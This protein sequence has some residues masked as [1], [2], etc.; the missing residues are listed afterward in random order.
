MG[1]IMAK[2]WKEVFEN[3]AYKD[4]NANQR[5]KAREQYWD[6]QIKPKIP[7]IKR[8]AV[9][10][11]FYDYT[12]TLEAPSGKA[13][14]WIKEYGKSSFQPIKR[15]AGIGTGVINSPLAFIW[16]SQAA[17]LKDP[18]QY[19]ALP[20]WKKV[21]VG[22]G[23]GFESAW[24]SATRKG[25]WGTLYGE[26]FEEKTGMTI[27]ESL[28][29]NLK[30]AAPTLEFTANLVSDPLILTPAIK[31]L[32]RFKIP[33]EF[34]GKLPSSFFDEFSKMEKATKEEK[35]IL[36]AKL[37]EIIKTREDYLTFFNKKFGHINKEILPA[38]KIK[39]SLPPTPKEALLV[40]K[41]QIPVDAQVADLSK[42]VEVFKR[43]MDVFSKD[44][45]L[46]LNKMNKKLKKLHSDNIPRKIFAAFGENPDVKLT[47]LKQIGL[48]NKSEQLDG[49]AR[50]YIR[51]PKTAFEGSEQVIQKLKNSLIE[52]KPREIENRLKIIE[53][54]KTFE[55]SVET[56]K[57]RMLDNA[58]KLLTFDDKNLNKAV[59]KE[60]GPKYIPAKIN[61]LKASGGVI[62]GVDEDENGNLV[63][64]V[65]KGLLGLVTMVGGVKL[66]KKFKKNQFEK[67][68]SKY[69]AWAR[70]TGMIGKKPKEVFDFAG[71]LS[72]LNVS[73]L[74]RF[75]K[76][77]D[78]SPEAY[79]QA[80]I[81]SSY[82]DSTQLKFQK[83]VD[84]FSKVKD[85]EV[86]MTDYILAHRA[87]DRARR[88]M[89][90]PN[91]V[92]LAEAEETIKNIEDYYISIGK[93][94]SDLKSSLR[95]F[96]NWT[97]KY[98][99]EDFNK[100]GLLSDEAYLKILEDNEWYATFDVIEHMP[101]SLDKIPAL[102]TREYFNVG[103]QDVIKAAKGTE[104][105][106]DDPVEATIRKFARAQELIARNKVVNT[107]IN[108]PKSQS[109]IRPVA[110]SKKEFFQMK[111]QGMNPIMDRA[112]SGNFDVINRMNNGRV[113]RYIAPKEIVEALKQLNPVQVPKMLLSLNNIFRSAA[114]TVYLPFTISNAFR[115][116][117]TAYTTAPVFK[118]TSGTKF[119]SSWAKGFWEGAKHEFLGSSDLVKDYI[120][121]GG[122][123][124]YIGNIRNSKQ[125]KQML[126]KKGIIQKSSDIVTSPFKLIEKISATIELAPR[127]GTFE[128]AI[129]GGY[130]PKDAA[131]MARQSTIDF[132]RGGTL[133]K[134]ANQIIPFLNSRVQ[135]KVVLANALKTKPTGTM[136][137]VFTAT[138]MPGF[139][140]YA[141]NNTYY[142]KE[143]ADIP[144]NIKDNYFVLITGIDKT[145]NKPQYIAIPKGDVGQLAWNP[146]EFGLDKMLEKYPEKT[147]DFLVDY[148]S[149]LS[150]IP[151]ARKGKLSGSKILSGITPPIVKGVIEDT[152]NLNLYTG[153]EIDPYWKKKNLPPELLYKENT[154]EMYKWLGKRY[155]ISPERL[156]NF[157]SNIVAGY[158]REG[159]DP[160][161]MLRGLTGRLIK[162]TSGEIESQAW[163]VM[164][165][166]EQGYLY[167][168]A[169]ANE[170]AKN[171]QKNKANQLLND[172]NK[173]LQTRVE[174]FNKRFKDYGIKDKGGIL[175]SYRFT[176]EKRKHIM[177]QRKKRGS[178]LEQKLSRRGR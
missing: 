131:M 75:A 93:S 155:K 104:K 172:W 80:R 29:D 76:L 109:F 60:L 3:P 136:A 101:E 151:F 91:N 40:G 167:T 17:P 142:A 68:L 82:K 65:G 36:Q 118:A 143:Y 135:S 147:G 127:L 145:K 111:N 28:P 120:N 112:W 11:Q 56:T 8:E 114:T 157:A 170:F 119:A 139:A 129:R 46:T 45:H 165:D 35:A 134:V 19:A 95:A 22:V 37:T 49:I 137:K 103:N 67:I 25:D 115:D 54:I 84:K 171:G 117:I 126:F 15:I 113:E 150:P 85:A 132:N 70:T 166:I 32:A 18:K 125:A 79:E 62:A 34:V 21:L 44:H 128:T 146:I 121:H 69:P 78:V 61:T 7:E 73:L 94:P 168:R 141:W 16:G 24:R 174:E 107:F 74:D 159:L 178:A 97:D 30:W 42:R 144:K 133:T 57:A 100:A 102:K 90:N 138:T 52:L 177:I 5:D 108:D 160:T 20:A 169:H 99:L 58:Q 10:K 176:G 23:G 33:K 153:H 72:R 83:L 105:L 92:T 41:S 66:A 158:G 51:N 148:L 55:A 12:E 39:K 38:G 154:P 81:F 175:K 4:L 31:N 116:A 71:L 77:K 43:K 130:L 50:H 88:G 26:Y 86:P 96:K 59:L 13:A 53:K 161:A 14:R 63:Y 110:G 149:D 27:E 87:A 152:A 156:R 122:G 123:F 9:Q 6:S 163:T 48:K 64:D 47:E 89:K 2:T 140:L 98:I 164:R 173:G 162:T 1:R 106:I 124:G